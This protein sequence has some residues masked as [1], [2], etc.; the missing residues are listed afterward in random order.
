MVEGS[1]VRVGFV[2][3]G[4]VNSPRDLIEQKCAAAVQALLHRGLDVVATAPVSDDPAQIDERRAIAELSAAEFDLLVVCVA[5]WIPSHTVIDVIT[6]W[7]HK[8]MVLWGLTGHVQNGR[9]V[10][11]ADQAGTA[12]LRDPMEAL[13]F[14]FKYV[15]DTYDA[16][17]AERGPGRWV[18]PGGACGRTAQARQD[19]LHG[20]PRHVALRHAG[21][22]CLPAPGGGAGHRSLR[23]AGDRPAH[24]GTGPGRGGS[25]H[26]RTE[27][28][29][30][31]R[32]PG[33]R[34]DARKRDPHVPGGDA[35]GEDAR[36]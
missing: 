18:C 36:L 14:K 23:D 6:H 35:E 16:P 17:Y 13:G 32:Q 34:C 15:Y 21:R 29:V 20:L 4:E 22:R 19:R 1:R 5:G 10:T 9:L 3:F 33:P 12:A 7:A 25:A 26:G 28:G 27:G 24:G 31:V 11:T 30:G 8:P 2:G